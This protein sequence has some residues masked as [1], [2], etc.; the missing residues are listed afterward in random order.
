MFFFKLFLFFLT[1]M[2]QVLLFLGE[3]ARVRVRRAY[4]ALAYVASRRV[5]ST[6]PRPR[7]LLPSSAALLLAAG[8]ESWPDAF[9]ALA[10]PPGSWP[11]MLA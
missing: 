8:D 4:V 6:R 2:C 3:R 9:L 11:R 1:L 10:I 7:A 5:A